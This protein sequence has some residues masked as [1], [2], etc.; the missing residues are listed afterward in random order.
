MLAVASVVGALGSAVSAAPASAAVP[1]YLPITSETGF[2]SSVY[3]SLRLFCPAGTQ[4]IGGGYQLVGAE[5]AVVLDD[6]IPSADNLLVG[7]GEIVGTGEPDDGTTADWKIVATVMCANP[8]PGYSIQA[9]TVTADI[10]TDQPKI[11]E[12]VC[13]PGRAVIGGGASLSNGFGQVSIEDLTILPTSVRAKAHEDADTY[14]GNWSVTVY[15]ICATSQLVGWHVVPGTSPTD[16]PL[17][18][19]TTAFCP[20]GQ[21]VIG[22]GWRQSVP[23]GGIDRYITRASISTNP[24]PSVTVSA[25][26]LT[27]GPDWI[28]AADAVCADRL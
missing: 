20:P 11:T 23:A 7:A 28:L 25:I 18:K 24:D 14:F 10:T 4:V 17:S 13:P 12:A 19:T 6:F 8:P 22:S 2:D 26:S 1:G 15:A 27:A 3:K 5:G 21:I 9:A 16:R